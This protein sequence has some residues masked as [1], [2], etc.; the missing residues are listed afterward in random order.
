MRYV[1]RM[2]PIIIDK[3]RPS[4]SFALALAWRCILSFPDLV[5]YICNVRLA[6]SF[7]L[8]QLFSGHDLSSCLLV[9]AWKPVSLNIFHLS[10][11]RGALPWACV[12]LSC[13][14][15]TLCLHLPLNS[16]EGGIRWKHSKSKILESKFDDEK[17]ALMYCWF[18]QFYTK[19]F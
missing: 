2:L 5:F 10:L 9:S 18:Y 8:L 1:P 13:D 15:N 3:R 11:V 7:F 14:V 12:H 17:T 16:Q 6:F 4:S 19:L